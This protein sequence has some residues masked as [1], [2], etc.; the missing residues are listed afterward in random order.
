MSWHSR[1][2]PAK[3]GG[4]QGTLHEDVRALRTAAL[5]LDVTMN[6]DHNGRV[7]RDSPASSILSH[8][9]S[10]VVSSGTS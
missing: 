6:E 9:L 4:N 2:A 5:V 10:R 1:P 8:S 7:K 3:A